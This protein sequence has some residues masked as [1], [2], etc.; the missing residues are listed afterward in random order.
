MKSIPWQENAMGAKSKSGKVRGTARKR[1]AAPPSR[2]RRRAATAPEA[3]EQT[4][5]VPDERDDEID[6]QRIV[7]GDAS[8]SLPLYYDDYN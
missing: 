3:W 8:R 2:R 1:A 4:A 7:R 6:C 5:Q